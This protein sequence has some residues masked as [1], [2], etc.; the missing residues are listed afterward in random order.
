MHAT[1]PLEL[2]F[3]A[4][5]FLR[6]IT[7]KVTDFATVMASTFLLGVTILGFC[8]FS[9]SFLAFHAFLAFLSFSTPFVAALMPTILREMT[10][11]PAHVT[12]SIL[13]EYAQIH[14]HRT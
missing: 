6:R 5:F 12:D 14:W 8:V 2:A 10:L 3:L 13:R 9:L 4:V 7:C 1:S 11:L